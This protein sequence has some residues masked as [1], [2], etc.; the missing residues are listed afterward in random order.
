MDALTRH[1]PLQSCH[2]LFQARVSRLCLR[3]NRVLSV[4]ECI[5]HLWT[6]GQDIIFCNLATAC[7]RQGSKNLILTPVFSLRTFSPS[8]LDDAAHG[9]ETKTHSLLQVRGSRRWLR[10]DRAVVARPQPLRLRGW[11]WKRTIRRKSGLFG[12]HS[13]P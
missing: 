9:S 2:S 8:T 7:L 1:Q 6:L 12:F 13:I 5:S 11:N 10:S 4:S 3:S